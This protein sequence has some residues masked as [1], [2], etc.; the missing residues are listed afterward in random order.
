VDRVQNEARTQRWQTLRDQFVIAYPDLKDSAEA[1]CQQQLAAAE[2]YLAEHRQEITAYIE[3]LDRFLASRKTNPRTAF[4]KN[5]D[6]D[7]MRSLRSEAKVWLAELDTREEAYKA[8][9][10][11]LARGRDTPTV[12]PFDTRWDPM[13]WSRLDLMR[14]LLPWG[15]AAIGLCLML[16]LLTR[17]AALAGGLFMLMVLLSQPSYPG[18]VPPDPPQMG[19]ALLVNKDF[20]EMLA[21]F[22]LTT[23]AVGHWGGLDF[24]FD[25]FVTAPLA[26]LVF[27]RSKKEG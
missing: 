23:T 8:A 5:R 17:P 11:N 19:H 12:D 6:W 2:I 13:N 20:V 9:L 27:R 26:S 3:A 21:L 16:G 25:R 1:V 18:V 7:E 15:L 4:Q 10:W 22:L 24:F 14:V